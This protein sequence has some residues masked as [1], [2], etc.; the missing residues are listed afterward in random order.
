MKRTKI[1]LDA[2]VG[3]DDAIAMLFLAGRPDAELV[4]V[5]SVHGNIP[6]DLAAANALRLLELCGLDDVPV[7]IGA[8]RPM[9]QPL[10]TAEWVH[11]ADGLGG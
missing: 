7:A 10:A 3:I 6:S 4:A 1:L 5:G 9:A 8:R 11:G 2:D